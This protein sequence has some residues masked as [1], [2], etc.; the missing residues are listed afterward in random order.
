MRKKPTVHDLIELKGKRP[1]TETFVFDAEEAAAA[2][3]AGIDIIC[4]LTTLFD[5]IRAAAPNT[6]IITGYAG[7][8]GEG[9]DLAR[10]WSY[11][12][13][14]KGADAVYVGASMDR[15]RA[16][17]QERIP[18]IGHIGYIPYHNTWYGKPRA[19]G[20]TAGEALEVFNEARDYD[21]AG[22][23]GVEMELVPSRV[24]HEITQRT[25]LITLGLGSGPGVDAHYCFAK[26]LL[27]TNRGHVPRHAKQ[28]A[29]LKQELDRLQQ[30]R[31]DAFKAYIADV[32]SAEYPGPEHEVDI[33]DEE[34]GKFMEGIGEN[35][36]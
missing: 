13:M 21:E 3:E 23:I 36:A 7:E 32:A 11:E 22:A 33:S 30:M 9:D 20:K 8:V 10:R 6:F 15:V 17:A 1:M 5:E 16:V 24:A 12:L 35:P 28:Y 34:F 25:N 31:I 19:V 27:G 18:V 29:D 14:Q 4:T 2:D 26:D